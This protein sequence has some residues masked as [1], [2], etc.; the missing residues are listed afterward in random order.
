MEENEIC[1]ILYKNTLNVTL[2]V[3]FHIY[4]PGN[5]SFVAVCFSSWFMF[6]QH[7]ILLVG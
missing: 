6:A 7:S 3:T 1:R 5:R 2:S 4:E